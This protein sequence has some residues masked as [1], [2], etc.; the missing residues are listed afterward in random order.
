MRAAGWCPWGLLHSLCFPLFFCWFWGFLL[1][2]LGLFP[3]P[4]CADGLL[5]AACKGELSLRTAAPEERRFFSLFRFPLLWGYDDTRAQI[6]LPCAPAFI[7][8]PVV[9]QGEAG[10]EAPPRTLLRWR[11]SLGLS[12]L[13]P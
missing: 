13:N 1:V 11:P 9:P 6:T 4:L 8:S 3:L 5:S 12:R 10:S 7:G 2:E